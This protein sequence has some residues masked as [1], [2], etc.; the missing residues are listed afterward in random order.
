MKGTQCK[1][2]MRFAFART[3]RPVEGD[4]WRSEAGSCYLIEAVRPSPSDPFK[5]NYTVTRLGKNAVEEGAEGV[6]IF[7]WNRR[8]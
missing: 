5:V 6:W 2:S 7:Q 8:R 3:R 1:L 4:F